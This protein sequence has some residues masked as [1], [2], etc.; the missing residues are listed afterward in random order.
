MTENAK[1]E[2]RSSVGLSVLQAAH[3]KMVFNRRVRVLAECLSARIPSRA[4]ILDIGCGDGT[5][6][7]LLAERWSEISIEGVEFAPRPQCRIPC[8]AFDGAKLPFADGSFDV[9]LFVDVLHHTDDATILLREARRVT[10][11]FVLIKDHLS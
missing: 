4:L 10:R 7:S 3:A 1:H 9:C 2:A 8:R 11:Q 6:G 5:I